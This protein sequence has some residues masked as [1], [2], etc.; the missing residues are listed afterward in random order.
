MKAYDLHFHL[1][2]PVLT[3]S[4][5]VPLNRN[6][7]DLAPG[8]SS[9]KGV[10]DMSFLR[11][12]EF[13]EEGEYTMHWAQV[14]CVISGISDRQWTCYGFVN[15]DLKDAD[16]MR[17]ACP[18]PQEL[19]DDV[20][21]DGIE[22]ETLYEEEMDLFGEEDAGCEPP[23]D[24][25]TN[26]EV[27]VCKEIQDARLYFLRALAAWIIYTEQNWDIM[28][29]DL[30]KRIQEYVCANLAPIHT[31]S[32][33]PPLFPAKKSQKTPPKSKEQRPYP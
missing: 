20:T 29:T 2:F 10:R 28:V 1:A 13:P 7:C 32:N 11:R 9:L 27:H 25:M 31:H 15:G 18:D 8:N 30:D 3:R 4:A 12:S 5:S 22:D 23:L 6:D 16:L 26:G 24:P 17:M 19:D 33:F 14:S 21:D